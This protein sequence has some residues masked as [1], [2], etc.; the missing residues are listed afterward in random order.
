[1]ANYE[2]WSSTLHGYEINTAAI[3]GIEL[4]HYCQLQTETT[5]QNKILALIYCQYNL[6]V[7]LLPGL[8]MFSSYPISHAR[9]QW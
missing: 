6:Q 1:M 3:S 5:L 2:Q 8:K 7:T 4:N 9:M